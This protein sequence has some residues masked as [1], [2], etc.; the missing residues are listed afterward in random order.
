MSQEQV[1]QIIVELSKLREENQRLQEENAYLKFK[2]EDR[3]CQMLWLEIF[4][5]PI[6]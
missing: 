2:L 4:L 3:Y 1:L 5:R 6:F